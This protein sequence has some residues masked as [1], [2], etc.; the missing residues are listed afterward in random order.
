MIRLA[1]TVQHAPWDKDRKAMLLTL[2]RRLQQFELPEGFA[3]TGPPRVEADRGHSRASRE[4]VWPPNRRAWSVA[5]NQ[6]GATHCLVLQDDMSPV[7]DFWHG[8]AAAVRARPNDILCFLCARQDVD[9]AA[10]DRVSWVSLPDGTWGGTT[11]MPLVT[12][13]DYLRWVDSNVRPECPS[14]DA[15]VDLYLRTFDLRAF[16]TVPSLVDHVGERSLIG[17]S[18][19]RVARELARSGRD[20]APQSLAFK[21]SRKSLHHSMFTY[22][23]EAA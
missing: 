6:H 8:V 9:R 11:L 13:I 14:A 4:G 17:H 19:G 16:A 5:A 21:R 20:F 3:L 10:A 2:L 23:K 15:R 1:V 22:L 12:A 18:K 7:P